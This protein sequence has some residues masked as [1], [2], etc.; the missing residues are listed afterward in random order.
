MEKE[1]NFVV[2]LLHSSKSWE[3]REKIIDISC[4]SN[5]VLQGRNRI[6]I[7]PYFKLE[8]EVCSTGVSV[9]QGDFTSRTH[10]AEKPHKYSTCNE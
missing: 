8:E 4:Y 6:K 1:S 7:E 3:P 5:S 10:S 2:Y 9:Q